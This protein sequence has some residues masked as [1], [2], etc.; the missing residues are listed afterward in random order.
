ML[1][2]AALLLPSGTNLAE[3]GADVLVVEGIARD[4]HVAEFTLGQGCRAFILDADGVTMVPE[5]EVDAHLLGILGSEMVAV[6]IRARMSGAISLKLDGVVLWG[7]VWLL[8]GEVQLVNLVDVAEVG[9]EV[10]SSDLLAALPAGDFLAHPSS[11]GGAF[12]SHATFVGFVA[13]VE[14]HS[15]RVAGHRLGFGWVG[16][17]SGSSEEVD[18]VVESVL[19][20]DRIC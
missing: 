16:F 3:F 7:L 11:V 1:V 17:K 19:E 12:S 2:L 13:E 14:G 8:Y 10:T 18:K 6:G 5:H 15:G 20:P 4:V 9:L